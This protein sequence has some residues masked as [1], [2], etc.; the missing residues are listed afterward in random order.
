MSD[1][2]FS[3]IVAQGLCIGCGVCAGVC[4]ENLLSIKFNEFGEYNACEDK[5][6]DVNCGLCLKVCPFF[7]ENENEDVLAK[8]LYAN[9]PEIQH[10]KETGYYLRSYYGYSLENDHRANG[11]SGGLTTWLLENLFSQKK[12][13][14][15]VCVTANNDHEKLFR[16]QVFDS[17]DSIRK[18][19]SSAYYPVELSEVVK[20]ILAHEGTFALVGLPC[21]IKAIRLAQ[22]SNS[23]LKE[24]V[25]FL[26]GLVCGQL[27]SKNYTSFISAMAGVIDVPDE[28]FYRRKDSKRLASNYAFEIKAANGKRRELCW[29]DGVG[30]VWGNR[31]FTPQACNYCD[32]VFAELADVSLMDAWLPEYVRDSKGA[33]LL[34]VRSVE[35]DRLLADRLKGNLICL[36]KLPIERI[37]KSQAGVLKVKRHHLAYRLYLVKKS[38]NPK[39]LKRVS[40]SHLLNF[41]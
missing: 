34:I 11:A 33:N 35:I 27:K 13:D 22:K 25:K 21:F 38:P 6:C 26:I 29:I 19:S 24:R 4:P 40:P 1:T 41:F 10:R 5:P 17:I 16:F 36:D 14:L 39:I 7:S 15:V 2:V 32:D 23:K 28:I 8:E 31:W 12:V 9:I 37:I 18:A 3:K 30:E 20:F